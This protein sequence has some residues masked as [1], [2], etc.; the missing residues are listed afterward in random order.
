MNQFLNNF[1]IPNYKQILMTEIQN[2]K[3][4]LGFRILKKQEN[5]LLSILFKHF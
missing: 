1:Q 2:S 3:Q 4:R 5:A